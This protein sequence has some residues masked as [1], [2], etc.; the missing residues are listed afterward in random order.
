LE[1][2]N[3]A[4]NH[5]SFETGAGSN[6]DLRLYMNNGWSSPL[7]AFKS[8]GFVGIGIANPMSSFHLAGTGT[9]HTYI[10]IDKVGNNNEG[11]VLFSKAGATLFYLFNDDIDNALKIQASGIAGEVD[12][13]PRM[14]FPLL[15][16]NIYMAES[17]GNVGIGTNNPGSFKLAVEG[18]IGAREINVLAGPGWPDYVFEKN[19]NLL[20]LPEV[21]DYINQNKHLPEVPAAKEMEKNGVNLGEMNMLLLKKVE[22]LTLYVIEQEK[23]IK[24]LEGKK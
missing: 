8:S 14:Q 13:T 16:K 19:Y 12:A 11:G 10:N 24:L 1:R 2:F 9:T 22:E 21:E 6:D 15:N 20:T 5:Y 23:R 3:S 7:M 17:G 4:G 18:K